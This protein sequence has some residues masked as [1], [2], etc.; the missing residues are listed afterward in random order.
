[1]ADH[2]AADAQAQ[3][4]PTLEQLMEEADLVV[5]GKVGE[6]TADGYWVDVIQVLRG[7]PPAARI[8]VAASAPSH[9]GSE[10]GF[11][12]AGPSPFTDLTGEEPSTLTRRI[13]RVHAGLPELE[14][15]SSREELAALCSVADVVALVRFVGLSRTQA[16]VDAVE[17]H[18]GSLPDQTTVTRGPVDDAQ[19]GG[20]W[21]FG[22]GS[23][24]FATVFL[25]QADS[26]WLVLNDRDPRL[27]RLDQ[28]ERACTHDSGGVPT[29]ELS[30]VSLSDAADEG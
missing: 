16:R 7:D 26:D 5:V 24:G 9:L 27:C 8:V 3:P 15:P 6:L 17:Y 29:H 1:M 30:N 20:G 23:E 21:V 14:P 11:V 12:L 13:L 22:A 2:S 4:L 25:Q 19:P 10:G 18:K 28:I